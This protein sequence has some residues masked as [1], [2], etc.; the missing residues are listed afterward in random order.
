MRVVYF[1]TTTIRSDRARATNSTATHTFPDR[2]DAKQ[3]FAR[4]ANI[5]GS[6]VTGKLTPPSNPV[7][8]LISL[9]NVPN[10]DRK[11]PHYGAGSQSQFSFS[12]IHDLS[13]P[14][15]RYIVLLPHVSCPAV[16]IGY[17]SL[18]SLA[19]LHAYARFTM[20]WS[21]PACWLWLQTLLAA[22]LYE[23]GHQFLSARVGRSLM[24]KC[25]SNKP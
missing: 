24:L 23:L 4:K 16:S 19:V 11:T 7:A 21:I 22:C 20:T 13:E 2:D 3:D 1:Q 8:G 10:S 25:G 18:C 17:Q 12:N 5:R 15:H 14:T 6:T 9:L